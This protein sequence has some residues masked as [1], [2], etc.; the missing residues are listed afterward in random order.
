MGHGFRPELGGART[1]AFLLSLRKPRGT[2]QA[3]VR[4]LAAEPSPKVQGSE[5]CF[6][7]VHSVLLCFEGALWWLVGS[8]GNEENRPTHV[9]GRILTHTELGLACACCSPRLGRAG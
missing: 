7:A 2:A 5:V 4:C 9:W 8:N 1:F 3:H 6:G